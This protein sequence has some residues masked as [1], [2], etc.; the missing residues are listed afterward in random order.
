MRQRTKRIVIFVLL[1][2]FW[3]AFVLV[4]MMYFVSSPQER[5]S[6]RNLKVKHNFNVITNSEVA[7]LGHNKRPLVQA[8]ERLHYKK[9]RDHLS[10]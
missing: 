10:T 3:S 5:A 4:I 2:P 1:T 9:R 6:L 7:V 8:Y